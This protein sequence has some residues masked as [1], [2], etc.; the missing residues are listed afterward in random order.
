MTPLHKNTNPFLAT[1]F[2]LALL[3][4]LGLPACQDP[5]K[6][7]VYSFISTETFYKTEDDALA[8][9]VA[10]Y[11]PFI[12][13]QY[14]QR[15]YYQ[16]LELPADQVTLLRNPT[17]MMVEN[18]NITADHPFMS[19]LWLGIYR[20]VNRANTVIDR[21]SKISMDEGKRATLVAE[22][23]FIR[24]YN[25]FN[26]VRLFGAVPLSVSE[27][28]LVGETDVPKGSVDEI[29]ELIINDL[30]IAENDLPPTRSGPELGR[31]TRWAAKT[32]LADVYLTRE[33]WAEAAAKAAE[34]MASGQH[35]LLND[36]SEVF[37]ESRENNEESIFSIQFNTVNG[38][39]IA[40]F[41]HAGGT[42]NPQC[43]SGVQVFQV[44]EKS[45]M[46]LNWDAQDGRRG[47]TVY[48]KFVN[49]AGK[50]VS[51]YDTP[52]PT[53]AFGK[54]NAPNEPAISNCP[55]N[56]H[57][58]RY[59]EVLLLFAEATSQANGGPNAAAYD[60]V[61]QVRRRAYKQ[62]LGQPSAFDLAPGLDAQAFRS[63]VVKERSYE[64]VMEGKRLYDLMRTNQ[65]PQILQTLGKSYNPKARLLPIPQ[66]EIDANDALT[67]ADQNEGY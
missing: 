64:F 47:F 36:F 24:A 54:Y 50:T 15:M 26:L 9:V 20:G 55:L 67:A 18:F 43:F 12:A 23:H 21:V 2:G 19:D 3:L 45:D 39:W 49:R 8:A 13:D 62:P 33:R 42:D 17:F 41:S 27:V 57:A 35:R 30:K 52:R 14:Y 51:V 10:A 40:S 16:V 56:L 63:A 44:D 46:W 29:Y 5:L 25:Y 61:N 22:G 38:H 66:A 59:A 53:P 37:R 6:E 4:T 31:A 11:Q 60:A 7:E 34:V 1:T 32:L 65:F 28:D 58:Y 48:D